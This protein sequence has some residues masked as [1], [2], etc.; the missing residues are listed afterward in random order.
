MLVYEEVIAQMKK[1]NPELIDYERK[2]ENARDNARNYLDF[3]RNAKRR[4]DVTSYVDCCYKLQFNRITMLYWSKV[5][6]EYPNKVRE[7]E[8][9]RGMD[10]IHS[11]TS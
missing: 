7:L 1:R 5:I 3:A 4:G 8:A 9:G 2:V 11:T 6:R 10:C